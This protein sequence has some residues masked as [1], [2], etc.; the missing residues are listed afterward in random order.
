MDEPVTQEQQQEQKPAAPV[1]GC[2]GNC[3]L[4]NVTQRQYCAAQISH[5]TSFAVADLTQMVIDWTQKVD[6][7]TQKLT[8]LTG[9]LQRMS[10]SVDEPL[11]TAPGPKLR[12]KRNA[13]KE[14][15]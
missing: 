4:C 11:I 12:R 10:V 2:S 6:E 3:M 9:A 1:S 7:I 14:T 5:S 8:E 15:E 13:T